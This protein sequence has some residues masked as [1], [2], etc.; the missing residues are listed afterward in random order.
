MNHAPRLILLLFVV[1]GISVVKVSPVLALRPF[2]T[3]DADVADPY[4]VEL[5]LGLFGFTVETEPGPDEVRIQ[6]PAFRFNL[7]L[8]NLG[9]TGDWEIVLESVHEF[10]D[11]EQED[12][13]FDSDINQFK[14]TG[15]F[16][17]NVWYRGE[18]WIPNFATEVGL[19]MPTERGAERA[20]GADFEGLTIFTWFFPRLTWHMTLGGATFHT[21]K[22]EP[23]E[24][25][26]ALIY[27]T[28]LDA[29]IP[30]HEKFHL[31]SEYSMEKVEEKEIEHQL[32]GGMVYHGPW[33]MD[34]D[35]A[36]F[37]GLSTESTD[38]GITAGVTISTKVVRRRDWEMK[39]GWRGWR[40]RK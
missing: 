9:F 21:G 28:I 24:T 3:T 35:A 12:E 23:G 8:P 32:L 30:G 38:W 4:E 2:V 27:G 26:G 33:G 34:W 40:L 31:V 10:I 18:G 37:G 14:A 39:K 36:G 11:K 20:R 1:I 5:E 25:R 15:G 6:S 16:F 17:K 13:D 29:P 19:L 7:G 22:E